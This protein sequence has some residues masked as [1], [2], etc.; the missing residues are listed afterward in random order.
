MKSSNGSPSWLLLFC[1]YLTFFFSFF[2]RR[3]VSRLCAS[4]AVARTTNLPW[5]QWSGSIGW[6][7]QGNDKVGPL[8][9][10]RGSCPLQEMSNIPTWWCNVTNVSSFFPSKRFLAPLPESRSVRWT[11][12]TP[13]SNFPR[14]R[15]ILGLRWVN[16]Y[17]SPFTSL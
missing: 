5:R 7:Y 17:R 9:V 13:S 4:R 12:T 1:S 16:R 8:D 10:Q 2:F 3:V 15:H 6:N 11:P 14:S